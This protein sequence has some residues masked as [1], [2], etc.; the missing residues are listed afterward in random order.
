MFVIL[1]NIK[2]ITTIRSGTLMCTSYL[3]EILNIIYADL[4]YIRILTRNLVHG[5]KRVVNYYGIQ[6]GQEDLLFNKIKTNK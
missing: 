2:T 4:L 1:K 6:R 5:N 3:I